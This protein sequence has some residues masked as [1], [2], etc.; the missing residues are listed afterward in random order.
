MY[1][2][3]LQSAVESIRGLLEVDALKGRL[4]VYG[5]DHRIVPASHEGGFFR[6]PQVRRT[7]RNGVVGVQL[8]WTFK[9]MFFGVSQI[10]RTQNIAHGIT[11]ETAVEF[12][13]VRDV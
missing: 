8:L 10:H 5:F 1:I 9:L 13:F 11:R 4:E 6:F 2:F 3:G 12:G 7:L